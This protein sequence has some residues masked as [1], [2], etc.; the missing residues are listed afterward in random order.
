MSGST[1]YRLEISCDDLGEYDGVLL[2]DLAVEAARLL[3][4]S[5][6]TA[7]VVSTS[8]R[9]PDERWTR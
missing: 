2:G 4:D 5:G 8:R 9:R 6:V 3:R 1:R 7:F